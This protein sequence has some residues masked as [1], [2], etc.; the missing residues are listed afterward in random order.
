MF[1]KSFLNNP[2]YEYIKWLS[3]KI[4]YQYKYRK[5]KLRIEYGSYLHNCTFGKYNWIGK[6]NS[7]VNVDMD[8]FSYV[9]SDSVIANCKIGKFCSIAPNVKIAPGKHPTSVFVST[10][11][12]TFS[13][14]HFMVKRFLNK[15][16]F[17]SNN[18]VVI[19]NDVWIGAN[20]LIVDGVEIA[21][22]AIIAANSVVSKNVGAYEI[23]GGVPAKLIKKRF[24]EDQINALLEFKWWNKEEKWIEDN[25]RNFNDIS[26]FLKQ[27]TIESSIN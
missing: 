24:D 19:G 17:V 26:L 6:N 4:K 10:H 16:T 14:P 22:G 3:I 20:C 9:A 2:L 13:N 25:I 15:D 21:D 11:P 1:D 5:S 23:V 27:V 12:A 7:L 18:K 8:D